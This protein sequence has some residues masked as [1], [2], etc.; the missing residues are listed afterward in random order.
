MTDA[1][2]S[3]RFTGN[4]ITQIGEKELI[5]DFFKDLLSYASDKA[6]IQNK[7]PQVKKVSSFFSET[8]SPCTAYDLIRAVFEA[9][10]SSAEAPG[11]QH[12]A[13]V[14]GYI[15]SNGEAII[16]SGDLSEISVS[17]EADD[18]IIVYTDFA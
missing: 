12:P 4:I 11:K 16:F 8:P 18:K 14:L 1:V 9:S 3:N 5:F 2:I 15:K 13:L 17:L 6:D 10:V 7:K